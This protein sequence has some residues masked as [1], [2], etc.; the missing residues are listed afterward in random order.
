VA[1]YRFAM[2]DQGIA[3]ATTNRRLSALGSLVSL[4]AEP[5]LCTFD[6]STKNVRSKACRDTP[7][8]GLDIM[9][10]LQNMPR[11]RNTLPKAARDVASFLLVSK[12]R[13]VRRSELVQLDLQ[14][15]DAAGARA[16]KEVV[17]PRPSRRA[18]A[19]R[20][21]QSVARSGDHC[22][23]N[24]AKGVACSSASA[25]LGW[26]SQDPPISR[27]RKLSGV[28]R[29]HAA[30]TTAVNE[31]NG[32]CPCRPAILR[33]R[34]GRGADETAGLGSRGAATNASPALTASAP[35]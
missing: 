1:A 21:E 3:P 19:A 28:T 35:R 7:S 24:L 33:A 23:R 25:S 15:F 34:F 22:L 4:A 20:L 13:A 12:R 11:H 26:H 30:I 29:P 17:E 9:V 8:P 16:R 27:A 10:A 6:P 14:D 32:K 5:S 2:I 31:T 18:I